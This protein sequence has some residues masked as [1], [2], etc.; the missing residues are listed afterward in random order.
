M[1]NVIGPRVVI[2]GIPGIPEVYEMP[3]HQVD[4]AIVKTIGKQK[5]ID[6]RLNITD[7]L[8]QNF[9]LLQDANGDGTLDR[10]NDQQMQFF[11]RGTY[12]TIGFTVRL[13]EPKTN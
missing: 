10:N 4:L 3:R 11:Q 12:Y 6:V 9:V 1:Y 5:N 2:V 13:L 8:N 7:L